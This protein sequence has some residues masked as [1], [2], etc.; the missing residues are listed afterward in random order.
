LGVRIAEQVKKKANAD[1]PAQP[2][3]PKKLVR[4]VRPSDV[5]TVTRVTTPAEWQALQ[6][7]L[8]QR[9]RQLLDEGFEVEVG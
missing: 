6:T 8:D 5:T 3:T 1:K 4:Q 9:V 2:A 7:K